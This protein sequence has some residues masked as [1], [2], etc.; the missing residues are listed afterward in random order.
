MSGLGRK[1]FRFGFLVFLTVE[2]LK[3]DNGKIMHEKE[4]LGL[5]L[6]PFERRREKTTP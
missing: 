5:S 6:L 2:K 4:K 1:C 3:K